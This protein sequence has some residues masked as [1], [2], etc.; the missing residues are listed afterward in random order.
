MMN[1]EYF[2]P[3]PIYIFDIPNASILNADLEK[4]VINWSNSEK[5]L[6]KTNVNG[7]HSETN[8]HIRPEYKDLVNILHDH[9]NC[10]FSGVYYIKTPE[11]CGHLKLEDPRPGRQLVMPVQKE[12]PLPKE[13]WREVHYKPIAGR[14]IMFPFWLNHMVEANESNDIRISVSFNFL[15]DR[16]HNL[17]NPQDIR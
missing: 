17:I 11:N 5:G 1:I 12:G 14:L 16:L 2:F 6:N 13:Y 8:M 9:P 15:Q 10:L 7:W 3:T 4:N